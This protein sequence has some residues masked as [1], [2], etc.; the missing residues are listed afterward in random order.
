[1]MK[2]IYPI[3]KAIAM[4]GGVIALMGIVVGLIIG[5]LPENIITI[6]IFEIGLFSL[7]IPVLMREAWST[8]K[9]VRCSL[10]GLKLFLALI[11]ATL[12]V[13]IYLADLGGGILT[14]ELF[15]VIA[16]MV[17]V[18]VM[19]TLGFD[20]LSRGARIIMNANKIGRAHV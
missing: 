2:S 14:Y 15:A 19:V 17:V 5:I 6:R 8:L 18:L 7:C 16:L 9:E 10:T 1:M 20:T 12:G 11:T 4:I 13:F 3:W